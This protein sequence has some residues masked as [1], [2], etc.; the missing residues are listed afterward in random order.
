MSIPTTP[1]YEQLLNY[2]DICNIIETQ[3][4]WVEYEPII[5]MKNGDIYGYEALARFVLNGKQIPPTPI[6]QVAHQV[7]ELFFR[8]ERALKIM[9]LA[10]RPQEG[11][12]LFVNIDPHN[13]S[14][15]EKIA[16]WHDLFEEVQ[17]ICIEVTENTDD[18]QTTLLS[19]CLDEIQKSGIPIAQDDIGNDKKPFC[20]YLTQRAQ[21]LKFDRTWLSKIRACEDYQEILKGFLAFA[22]AQGKKSVLEGVESEEDFRI[23]KS[24]GV[25]FVQGYIF[26]HLNLSSKDAL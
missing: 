12:M 24:L 17:D 15:S 23:A 7:K 22:K 20:F 11:G 9:Q 4:F 8:L 5:D 16:Y 10:H 26:K 14:D 21:F 2:D 3:S 6:L 1:T 13:F 19:H 18:M 25:D